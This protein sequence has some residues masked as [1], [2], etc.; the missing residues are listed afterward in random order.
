[1][2][3]RTE[4][5]LPLRQSL[6]LAGREQ[7]KHNVAVSVANLALTIIAA[8][9]VFAVGLVSWPALLAVAIP[10]TIAGLGVLIYCIHGLAKARKECNAAAIPRRPTAAAEGG[11]ECGGAPKATGDIPGPAPAVEPAVENP[12]LVSVPEEASE[13]EQKK[14][15]ELF[16]EA[17]ALRASGLR[18]SSYRVSSVLTFVSSAVG[19]IVS[20]AIGLISWP[21]AL[22]GI[23]ALLLCFIIMFVYYTLT[24]R[25]HGKNLGKIIGE[26]DEK[27][28]ENNGKWPA[29]SPAPGTGTSEVNGLPVTATATAI[30][31]TN[32]PELVAASDEKEIKDCISVHRMK[33]EVIDS[34]WSAGSSALIAA[35]IY[36]INAVF[37]VFTINYFSFISS[38]VFTFSYL[39]TCIG[40]GIE[41]IR[42]W[43]AR[44]A[45]NAEKG[46]IE[47]QNT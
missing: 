25:S 32:S 27:E 38:I 21:V 26:I 16:G 35:G 4:K 14:K 45:K 46:E 34:L 12:L 41:W 9:V 13:E 23:G 19:I 37:S 8:A 22:I 17:L 42:A 24:L 44:T 5:A 40:D 39:F 18:V 28:P 7:A 15:D 20:G 11:R 3:V 10:A 47:L 6:L 31:E 43:K 1:M 2:Q 30:P 29:V 36:A 33:D